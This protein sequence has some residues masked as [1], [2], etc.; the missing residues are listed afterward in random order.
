MRTEDLGNC[1]APSSELKDP[2]GL[3]CFNMASS[4]KSIKERLEDTSIRLGGLTR[5]VSS[6]ATS[7][8][9]LD[10]PKQ[11]PECMMDEVELIELY[12]TKIFDY[13]MWL[14]EMMGDL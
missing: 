7:P 10:T 6:R 1:C 9:S 5:F 13:T 12:T 11:V 4:L 8:N 2:K 3:V 14:C